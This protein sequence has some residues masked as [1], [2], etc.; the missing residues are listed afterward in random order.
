MYVS[1]LTANKLTANVTLI[2]AVF[3]LYIITPHGSI[4]IRDY[5]CNSDSTSQNTSIHVIV[6]IAIMLSETLYKFW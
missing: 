5:V 3:R 4:F 1:N 2:I 6:F